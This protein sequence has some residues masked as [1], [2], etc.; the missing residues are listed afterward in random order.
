MRRSCDGGFKYSPTPFPSPRL[1]D[2][3]E[4]GCVLNALSLRISKGFSLTCKMYAKILPSSLTMMMINQ[5]RI[6]IWADHAG[7][8][9]VK[10]L[11]GAISEKAA[12][13]IDH[14]NDGFLLRNCGVRERLLV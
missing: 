10:F 4:D 6:H 9:G 8:W 12:N 11:E 5:G 13:G 7:A 2:A 1:V 3:D 14:E